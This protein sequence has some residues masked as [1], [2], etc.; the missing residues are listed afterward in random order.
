MQKQVGINE[1]SFSVEVTLKLRMIG[2]NK[3]LETK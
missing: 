1:D 2:R 3:S